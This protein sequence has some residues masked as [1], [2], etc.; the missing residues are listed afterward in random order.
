MSLLDTLEK[1]YK[2]LDKCKVK[3]YLFD[4]IQQMKD[5]V[6]VLE[7]S[8]SLMEFIIK[9]LLDYSLIKHGVFK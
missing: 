5:G 9:N 2:K 4:I 8:A 1:E 6:E 7:S 3:T